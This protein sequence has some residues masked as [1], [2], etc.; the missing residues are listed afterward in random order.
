MCAPVLL[1][2]LRWVGRHLD[3][4][5]GAA[6]KSV[7]DNFWKLVVWAL[8][9]FGGTAVLSERALTILEKLIG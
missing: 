4:F 2:G 1:I 9:V 3:T 6:A 5:V 8:V 7:G